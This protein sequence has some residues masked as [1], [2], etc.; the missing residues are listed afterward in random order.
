MNVSDVMGK[1]DY[2]VV[3]TDY[4]TYAGIYDCQPLTALAHRQNAA[5]LSRTPS[6]DS[7]Y[8]DKVSHWIQ[9]IVTS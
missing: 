3:G 5:I 4:V 1:G 2:I 7:M 8:V 6:L 9:P